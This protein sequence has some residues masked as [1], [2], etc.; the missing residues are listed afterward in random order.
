LRFFAL[1]DAF[2]S[3]SGSLR[4]ILDRYMAAHADV[5]EEA[6]NVM[7]QEYLQLLQRLTDLF[8]G[9][10]FRLPSGR[11]SRPLYDALM[12]ALSRSPDLDIGSNAQ[13][14]RSTLNQALAADTETY[15]ILVGRGNTMAAIRARAELARD[16]LAA[17]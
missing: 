9:R 15:E 6:A 13:K 7:K 8:E 1:R 11:I 5:D 2:D 10:P 12:I 14:I 16:I 4:L 3:G 17:R